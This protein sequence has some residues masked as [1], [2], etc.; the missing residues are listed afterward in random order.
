MNRMDRTIHTQPN[1][2]SGMASYVWQCVYLLMDMR[3]G[4][5]GTVARKAERER[6]MIAA[7][8]VFAACA[9]PC[10]IILAERVGLD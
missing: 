1:L 2:Q 3:M 8:V 5:N 4:L 9:L 6:R 10:P 7:P